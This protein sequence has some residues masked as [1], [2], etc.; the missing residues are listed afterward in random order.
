VDVRPDL[1]RSVVRVSAVV[2]MRAIA[3]IHIDG[4]DAEATV[5]AAAAAILEADLGGDDAKFLV[6]EAEG[7]EL[8]WY[9][10]QEIGPL[11]ESLRT[12]GGH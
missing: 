5:R 3:A 11:L 7:Y 12:G 1:D 9:A 6:D 8:L 2:P 10:N 4:P